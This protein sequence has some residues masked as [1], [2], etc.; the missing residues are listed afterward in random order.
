MKR[1]ISLTESQAAASDTVV[2]D[3]TK[4]PKL[5]RERTIW[6]FAYLTRSDYLKLSTDE[7]SSLINQY[8]IHLLK[9]VES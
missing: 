4:Y 9:G 8:Y 3:Q 7:K 6:E 5:M 1:V 2:I